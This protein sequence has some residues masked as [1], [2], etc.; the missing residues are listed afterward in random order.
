[1][2]DEGKANI[3]MSQLAVTVKQLPE[4]LSV[5]QGQRLL[6][7]LGPGLTSNRPCFVFDCSNLRQ[8]DRA[9]LLLLLSCLEEAMKSN[10]DVRLAAVSADAKAIL[11]S[12]GV[13]RLFRIFDLSADAVRSFYGCLYDV[14]PNANS[15]RGSGEVHE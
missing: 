1:M 11:K 2:P 13:N 15:F 3:T 7:E 9:T 12:T 5:D 4:T 10:G 8:L 14:V 6:R